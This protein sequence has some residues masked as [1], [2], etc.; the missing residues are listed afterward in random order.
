[1]AVLSGECRA[2]EQGLVTELGPCTFCAFAYEPS[3]ALEFT[4]AVAAVFG[5]PELELPGLAVGVVLTLDE[6]SAGVLHRVFAERPAAQAHRHAALAFVCHELAAA[7]ACGV[8]GPKPTVARVIAYMQAHL[9][10]PLSLDEVARHA[11]CSK[12]ALAARF[13]SE[14]GTTPMRHLAELRIQHARTC[15]ENTEMTVREV[16]SAVGYADVAAFSHFFKN[17]TGLSPSAARA[18]ARWVL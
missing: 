4:D 11:G 1:V 13:R 12:S 14:N 10:E 9:D 17:H 2:E 16:A 6:L 7:G 3:L 18:N 15:L 5:I 8:P